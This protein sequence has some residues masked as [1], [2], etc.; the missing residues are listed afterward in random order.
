VEASTMLSS[1]VKPQ[2]LS[3]YRNS[4]YNTQRVV[5]GDKNSHT[6]LL[7]RKIEMVTQGLQPFYKKILK[8][9]LSD[10]NAITVSKNEKLNVAYSI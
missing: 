4:C 9:R 10:K 5:M 6:R 1:S 8:K 3:S 2:K 7:D